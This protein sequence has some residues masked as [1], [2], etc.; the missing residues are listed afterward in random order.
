MSDGELCTIC[1]NI[2]KEGQCATCL[3][4]VTN[5]IKLIQKVINKR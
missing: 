3:E 4:K 1:C 2:I 5:N